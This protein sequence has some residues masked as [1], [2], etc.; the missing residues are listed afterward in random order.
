MSKNQGRFGKE[1]CIFKLTMGQN[2]DSLKA[3]PRKK[4][5]VSNDIPV[6]ILK[7]IQGVLRKK[8]VSIFKKAFN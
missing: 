5:S 1:R 7:D 3:L 4:A 2:I 6:S 8:Q